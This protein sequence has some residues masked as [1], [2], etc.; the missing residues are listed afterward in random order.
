MDLGMGKNLIYNGNFSDFLI[1]TG[2]LYVQ[3]DQPFADGILGQLRDIAY[4]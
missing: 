3:A 4:A 1:D 2:R